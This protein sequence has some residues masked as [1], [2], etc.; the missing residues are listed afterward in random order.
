MI[1]TRNAKSSNALIRKTRR[2]YLGKIMLKLLLTYLHMQHEQ[3]ALY[4][5][6]KNIAKVGTI[7][8]IKL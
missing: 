5:C 2:Y 1:D 6:T 3:I 7:F 4:L 8:E